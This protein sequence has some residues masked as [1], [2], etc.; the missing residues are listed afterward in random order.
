MGTQVMSFSNAIPHGMVSGRPQGGLS[1][2]RSSGKGAVFHFSTHDVVSEFVSLL[3]DNP[4]V[5]AVA[6]NAPQG[7]IEVWTYIDPTDQHDCG[8]IDKMQ[9]ELMTRYPEI[10]FDFSAILAAPGTVTLEPEHFGFL[11]RLTIAEY[12]QRL[13]QQEPVDDSALQDVANMIIESMRQVPDEVMQSL[14]KDGASQHDHYIYGWPKR[15]V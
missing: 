14:P 1:S 15:D 9:G 11:Q 13:E 2:R 5:W 3:S 7:G 6:A 8:A 12:F 4:R 10:A